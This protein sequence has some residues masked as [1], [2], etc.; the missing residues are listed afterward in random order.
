MTIEKLKNNHFCIF[1]FGF[2]DS[3]INFVRNKLSLFGYDS[4][5]CLSS[6]RVYKF[7]CNILIFQSIRSLIQTYYL[8]TFKK[9]KNVYKN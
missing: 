4:F 3:L 6:L 5:E 8:L 9:P 1:N 2:I 7:V